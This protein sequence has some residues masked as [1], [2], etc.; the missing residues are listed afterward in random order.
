M[1]KLARKSYD[2]L[3]DVLARAVNRADPPVRRVGDTWLLASKEDAWGLLGK[4]LTREDL[5]NFENVV[6]DVLGQPD[7]KLRPAYR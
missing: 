6:L 4:Y 5:E 3:N 2:E 1:G 7:P